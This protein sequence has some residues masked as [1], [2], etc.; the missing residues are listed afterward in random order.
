MLADGYTSDSS[1]A[2]WDQLSDIDQF[3]QEVPCDEMDISDDRPKQ[4]TPRKS[5]TLKDRFSAMTRTPPLRASQ[6]ADAE[7]ARTPSTSGR[8]D[9]PLR[10][11]FQRM[12]L[13]SHRREE[14]SSPTPRRYRP[15]PE[16]LNIS[17]LDTDDDDTSTASSDCS[18]M[19]LFNWSRQTSTTSI[20][21]DNSPSR[22]RQTD[23]LRSGLSS[24]SGSSTVKMRRTSEKGKTPAIPNNNRFSNT[25]PWLGDQMTT[26][27]A[28]VSASVK[29]F[30]VRQF[31][32]TTS[33]ESSSSMN[34]FGSN[35]SFVSSVGM[36]SFS[37]LTRSMSSGGS[38]G[39]ANSYTTDDPFRQPTFFD[40]L[41]GSGVH[42]PLFVIAH[43]PVVQRL[44]DDLEKP[45]AWGTQYELARGVTAKEWTWSNVEA[46]IEFFAGK[47][48]KEVL[49]KVRDIMLHRAQGRSS[50]DDS[51]GKEL[52]REQKALEENQGRGLGLMGTW[53]GEEDWFGGQIQQIATVVKLDG[54]E[55]AFTMRLEPLEMRRSTRFARQ[56]G[57][58]RILQ[59]RVG[60]DLLMNKDR[61]KVMEFL[62]HQFVLNGRVFVVT[63]PKDD[64]LYAV[65]VNED[66]QRVGGSRRFGDQ[67]RMG[68]GDFL[69]WH[70]PIEMNDGQPIAKYFARA[71]LGL[72]NT[73][74]VLEFQESDIEFIEDEVVKGVEGKPKSHQIL[75]DGCGF[76]NDAALQEIT[77]VMKYH[78]L[79][80]AAQARVAGSKGLFTRHPSDQSPQPRIWIRDSQR[81]I[82][83]AHL[84]RAHRIFDLVSVSHSSPVSS[85]VHLSQ[86]SVLNMWSNG[87]PA[88]VFKE[89]MEQGLREAIGPLTQWEGRWAMVQLWD[90]INKTGRVAGTRLARLAPMMSRAMGFSG[91]EWKSSGDMGDGDSSDGSDIDRDVVDSNLSKMSDEE[92]REREEFGLMDAPVAGYYSG[93]N[94][95]SG[96]PISLHEY[97]LELVQAGFNPRDNEILWDKIRWILKNTISSYIEKSR[98]PLPEGTGIEAFVIPDPLGVLKEGEIYYRSSNPMKDPETQTLFNVAKGPVL[99]YIYPIRLPS[100]IQMVEAVDY[101]GLEKWSD[102]VIVPIKPCLDVSLYRKASFMSLLSGGDMDGDTVFVTW[103]KPLVENFQNKS[104][105]PPPEDLGDNFERQVKEVPNFITEITD[106]ASLSIQEA[107]LTFQK[108]ALS[109]LAHVN[110]GMYSMFHDVA[111]WYHGYTS[112]HAKRLAYMFNTILDGGKTGLRLLDEVYLEDKRQADKHK[113][114][115]VEWKPSKH[116]L[117]KHPKQNFILDVL[118]EAGE[119][120]GIDHLTQFDQTKQRRLQFWKDPDL[121]QPLQ[122]AESA[123]TAYEAPVMPTKSTAEI[124]FTRSVIKAEL[125]LLKKHVDRAYEAFKKGAGKSNY[126]KPIPMGGGG[127]KKP[128]KRPDVMREAIMLYA[129]PIAGLDMSIIGRL[130][131]LER[132]KASYACSK[133][134]KFGFCVAFRELCGI[135]AE[136]GGR[137]GSVVS[138]RLLDEVR[139]IPGSCRRLYQ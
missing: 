92:R 62:T 23:D 139:S 124:A 76:I 112:Q 55:G 94:E 63:P 45:V 13:T 123:A 49:H 65:E 59:V 27:P 58:R 137:Q 12:D 60:E 44:F 32:R 130:G 15:P 73:T 85:S 64:G 16:P 118:A 54:S 83:Y 56:L 132:I 11:G 80:T 84:S 102:V 129:Q 43:N 42:L 89:L 61:E 52:D 46:E 18:D 103:Y 25:Q 101:P 113:P 127:T 74:P 67:Y 96:A 134:E 20:E 4:E 105:F 24:S 30:P 31:S 88:D 97:A 75:T 108:A 100:D 9:T 2:L 6:N 48:D 1:D 79:P 82:K 68:M 116:R 39:P 117:Q 119:K 72:S 50:W 70:N 81:K 5:E 136:A 51:I 53:E 135:K 91:R 98:F 26:T 77:R 133:T 66:Y 126:P 40:N 115:F 99:V 114:S 8:G 57:S 28:S 78:S 90:T 69:E 22:K 29:T 104:F 107:Q 41:W 33:N 36:P 86:Q 128:T 35:E 10:H 71:A 17:D 14:P 87:V 21:L 38:F 125:D 109:G 37:S 111:V 34:S 138:I 120:M 106:V 95:Y 122:N 121:L 47:E 19:D 110:V 7:A 3:C 93:R 131:N